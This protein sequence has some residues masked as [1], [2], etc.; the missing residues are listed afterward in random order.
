V[1]DAAAMEEFQRQWATYQKLVDTATTGRYCILDKKTPAGEPDRGWQLYQESWETSCAL[2]QEDRRRMHRVGHQASILGTVHRV[3]RMLALPTAWHHL[4][5]S[6]R[7][8]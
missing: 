7:S 1:V 5:P 4:K 3:R 2:L 8:V 6:T